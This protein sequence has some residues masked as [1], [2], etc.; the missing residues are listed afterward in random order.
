MQ[1]KPKAPQP[2]KEE[3][4]SH[5]FTSLIVLGSNVTCEVTVTA[6]QCCGKHLTEPETDC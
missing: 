1:N 4:C 3:Q 2:P 6:C 5:P